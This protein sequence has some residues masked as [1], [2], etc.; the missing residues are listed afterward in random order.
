MNFRVFA[1]AVLVVGLFGSVAHAQ[2][3]GKVTLT[4][5]QLRLNNRAIRA[6]Q[7]DPPD[8][9]RAMKL[10]QAARLLG[11]ANRLVMLTEGRVH[12]TAGRCTAA[13]KA[14]SDAGA[15][16]G[17]VGVPDD[18]LRARGKSYR[19]ELSECFGSI[20][21]NCEQ[22]ASTRVEI[23]G[24]ARA[25]CGSNHRVDPGSHTL[26]VWFDGQAT[27][28]RRISVE[29]GMVRV[30]ELELPDGFEASRAIT[31]A[32]AGRANA[33]DEAV[34]SAGEASRS[35]ASTAGR[36]SDDGQNEEPQ[37]STAASEAPRKRKTYF[38]AG[39]D[40]DAEDPRIGRPGQ[41]TPD[42]STRKYVDQE[43]QEDKVAFDVRL[44]S[45]LGIISGNAIAT[46][47]PEIDV[48]PGVAPTFAHFRIGINWLP[49]PR[50]ML[51]LVW[52]YQFAPAQDLESLGDS[53]TVSGG[54]LTT[55]KPCLG[56]G[57]QG[58]CLFGLRY[59]MLT[60][61]VLDKLHGFVDL[62]LGAGRVRHWIR[63]R[64]ETDAPNGQRRCEGK[65]LFA[66]TPP[67][68]SEPVEFCFVK[69]TARSGGVYA[70]FG[71]G[72]ALPVSPVF[73]LT[74]D[75]TFIVLAPDVALNVD[76]NLGVNMRF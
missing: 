27:R 55:R 15:L 38:R 6:I 32:R 66:E 51:G 4:E 10:V 29:P 21:I 46:A 68:S 28:D 62:E 52:R 11:E 72:A 50:S 26:S 12:H 74:A 65:P 60:S 34:R 61:H 67:G 22:P 30:I 20:V 64:Q 2:E 58:E 1:T 48:R 37:R 9:A 13:E 69:D 47:H 53:P 73:D 39:I 45:G 5:E 19:E 33:R 31:V 8:V 35:L 36:P 14:Y 42:P 24:L 41:K 76:F 16:P 63:L 17:V 18:A 7:Q 54:G 25:Q 3:S 40:G 44:G 59:R 56:I 57:L 43:R 71:A 23:A 70:A 49:S 75:T